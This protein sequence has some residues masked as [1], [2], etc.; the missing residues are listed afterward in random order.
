ML[1]ATN[2]ISDPSS[3]IVYIGAACFGVF[4]GFL[5][6]RTMVNN[7]AD[8]TIGDIAT[9]IGAVGG[10]AITG[11]YGPANG[12]LFA[13]YTIGLLIGLAVFL[14]FR[15]LLPAE[16]VTLLGSGGVRQG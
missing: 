3:P 6:Y 8:T 15:L 7:Q 5:T 2:A 14:L 16:K 4:V 12:L 9:V 13:W 10:A 11:L 1:S